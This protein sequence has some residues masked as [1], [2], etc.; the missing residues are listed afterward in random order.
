[1]FYLFL[2]ALLLFGAGYGFKLYD[3]DT[4]NRMVLLVAYQG[5]YVYTVLHYHINNIYNFIKTYLPTLSTYDPK[6]IY[7][8][9]NDGNT[10]KEYG[11]HEIEEIKAKD[12]YVPEYNFVI[13]Y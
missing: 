12:Y 9:D 11:I 13:Y 5:I 8:I 3:P 7:L 1:M 10:I 6:C 4:S 2:G